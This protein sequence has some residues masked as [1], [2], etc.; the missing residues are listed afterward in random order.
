MIYALWIVLA[1]IILKIVVWF[2]LKAKFDKDFIADEVHTV[3]CSDGWRIN[4]YRRFNPEAP[5]EPILICHGI[6][7]NPTNFLYPQDHAMVDT[8][9][10]QGYDCWVIDLRGNRHSSPP[11]G[12][13]RYTAT[14]DDYYMRDLPAAIDHIRTKT[15]SP[16]VHWIGHS[17]GGMLLYTYATVHGTEALASGTTLGT[18]PGFDDLN[19]KPMP[20][21]MALLTL[22]PAL[23]DPWIRAL[24][25][26]GPIV[27]ISASFAPINWKNIA[28]NINFFSTTEYAPPAVA[29]QMHDWASTNSWVLKEANINMMDALPKLD[30]PLHVLA[31]SLDPLAPLPSIEKFHAG[32]AHKDTRFTPLGKKYG[33]ENEYNHVD[34]VFSADGQEEV[35]LPIVD[36]LQS[37]PIEAPKKK[38]APRKKTAA[39][40]KKSAPKAK[41]KPKG[42][43]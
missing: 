43:K 11:L 6:M 16:S 29:Q 32:L 34:L 37:H 8:L 35:Y 21:V 14:Y 13:S 1:I 28:S 4:L 15:G 38:R 20:L 22:C 18:P 2:G 42:T 31:G 41:A 27:K 10:E 5:G 30:I 40:K 3:R 9:V 39:K 33:C 17:M 23:A 19:Q 24:A 26:L 36:W 12:T 7:G 25:S